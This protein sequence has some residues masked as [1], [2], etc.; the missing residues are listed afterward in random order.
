M[1]RTTPTIIADAQAIH[2]VLVGFVQLFVGLLGLCPVALRPEA[3]GLVLEL[4]LGILQLREL[5]IRQL[6]VLT[7]VDQEVD[8]ILF[9]EVSNSNVYSLRD[10][11]F[12]H[13][14]RFLV[15]LGAATALGEKN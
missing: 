13:Q 9:L 5:C 8:G 1:P 4:V 12:F 11:G 10:L 2:D 6:E 15:R 14:L 7:F 3:S